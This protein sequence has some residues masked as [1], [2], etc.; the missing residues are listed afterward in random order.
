MSKEIGLDTNYADLSDS[1]IK[2][3]F[4]ERMLEVTPMFDQIKES[5]ANLVNT[6]NAT[7][8]EDLNNIHIATKR[9][10]AEVLETTGQRLR[11]KIDDNF[12]KAGNLEADSLLLDFV[13]K[14]GSKPL[15]VGSK[16]NGGRIPNWED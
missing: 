11:A 4:I 5:I 9:K 7:L 10:N 6:G 3:I 14:L 8:I 1:D 15:P 12:E 16:N 2:N 13:N